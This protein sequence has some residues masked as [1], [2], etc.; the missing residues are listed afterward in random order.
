MTDREELEIAVKALDSRKAKNITAL[1]VE[2]L[3][4][5][6]N[7]FVIASATSTTQ[8]KALADEVEYQLGEKGVKPR[9]IEGYQSQTWIVLD[10]YDIIVHVFLEETRDFYQLERLWADG[11]PVDISG[12]TAE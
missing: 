4:I 11:T 6:A 5:L 1:K 10:Y 2:N 8:V 7:Y 3:T 12:M 9:S